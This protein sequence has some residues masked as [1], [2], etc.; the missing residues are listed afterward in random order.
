MSFIVLEISC[1]GVIEINLQE[2]NRLVAEEVMRWE[3]KGYNGYGNPFVNKYSDL[4][5]SPFNPSGDIRDA[6]L[7]VERFKNSGLEISI[8]TD[9]EGSTCHIIDAPSSLMTIWEREADT[10]P[11][12]ICKAA[13]KAVGVEVEVDG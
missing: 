4:H 10:V 11:L 9:A 3:V 1:E 6:W 13:L 12:A 7:V 2:I 5:E 8:Y